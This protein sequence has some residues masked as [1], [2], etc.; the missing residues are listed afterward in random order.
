MFLEERKKK[1]NKEY[2][3]WELSKFR[4]VKLYSYS[5]FIYYVI[6][7]M[8]NNNSSTLV[9]ARK[10]NLHIAQDTKKTHTFSYHRQNGYPRRFYF[11]P[12]H[13]VNEVY[14]L[15]NQLHNR[16]HSSHEPHPFR[17]LFLTQHSTVTQHLHSIAS[18]RWRKLLLWMFTK[19][20]STIESYSSNNQ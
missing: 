10:R 4:R 12:F 13:S 17:N 11:H 15:N 19:I 18:S 2:F 9:S 7:V 1:Y 20:N 16:I 8:F 6:Y 3:F 5:I 14:Y